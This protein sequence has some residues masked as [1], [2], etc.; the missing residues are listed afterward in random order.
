MYDMLM[1]VVMM[2]ILMLMLRMRRMRRMKMVYKSQAPS[3]SHR[4]A[5]PGC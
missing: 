4:L 5:Q 2:V 3:S 1:L